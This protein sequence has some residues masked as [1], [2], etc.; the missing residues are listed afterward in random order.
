MNAIAVV[1]AFNWDD[2]MQGFLDT[3]DTITSVGTG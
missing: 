1:Y 3:Q 2:A